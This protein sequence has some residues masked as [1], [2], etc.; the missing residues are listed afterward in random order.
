MRNAAEKASA[1]RPWLLSLGSL[2][3][4]FAGL[5]I[6]INL[7]PDPWPRIIAAVLCAGLLIL[8]GFMAA[9]S[10]MRLPFGFATWGERRLLLWTA[11]FCHAPGDFLYRW[12]EAA[13][14]LDRARERLTMAAER[15]CVPAMRE[16][17]RDLLDGA[18]GGMARGA[19][20]PWLRRAA[21]AG[22]PESDYWLGEALR[23]GMA[24]GGK[25]A[26]ALACYL[27]AARG[28]Y[29][30]AAVWLARAYAVGDGIEADA[31]QAAIWA[32]RATTLSGGETPDPGL[33]R[34]MVDRPSALAGVG[35][36]LNEA[37]DQ[38]GEMLWTQRWFRI[39]TWTLT[40]LFLL[41]ATLVLLVT[42]MLIQ[43]VVVLGFWLLA[44]SMLLRLYGL[45]PSRTSRSTRKLEARAQAGELVACFELGQC[46]ERGHHDL[47]KDH[48]A[49]RSWYRR[50]VAGGHP[51]A[52]LQLADL[53]SWG[54]GG[55]KDLAEARRLLERAAA[56]GMPEAHARLGRLGT[57]LSR[58]AAAADEAPQEG[59][60]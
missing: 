2:A 32:K 54:L 10:Y 57:G 58:E 6:G 45:G 27:R 8:L 46:Y 48:G 42:P 41:M 39:V 4:L 51:E 21:E 50:A 22:D 38:I 33:L 49:A 60:T 5:L 12:A 19:G 3:L 24:E 35:E 53:L 26:D 7:L 30:P 9:G 25:P 34:R 43:L 31:A 47:P 55:P 13:P 37:A 44:T 52:L 20:L 40:S 15:G 36:D 14:S 59:A 56:L 18:M 17:G 1:L 28:G 11:R 23:W 16:L 29:R